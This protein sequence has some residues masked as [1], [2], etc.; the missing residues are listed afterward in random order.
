MI[1][2]IIFDCDGVVIDSE[3]VRWRAFRKLF[4]DEFGIELPKKKDLSIIGKTEEVNMGHFLKKYNLRRDIHKLIKKKEEI[5]RKILSKKENMIP[6]R[7][8]FDFLEFLKEK[9][10]RTAV[11]SSS[12]KPYINN[13]LDTFKI[14]N[15]FDKI[16]SGDMVKKSKPEPDIFILAAEKLCLKNEEC[17]V[18]EDS[19]PGVIAAKKAGMICIAITSTFKRK[20]LKENG[21]DIVVNSLDEIIKGKKIV[22]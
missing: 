15:K 8:L 5:L 2:G 3:P 6:V 14:R 21:A 12:L 16:I 20:E 13:V 4:M 18:I 19:I 11:A 17:V 1:K 10:Y 9:G 7:G 22:L